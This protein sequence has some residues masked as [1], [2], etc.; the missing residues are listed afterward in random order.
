MSAGPLQ[1]TSASQAAHLKEEEAIGVLCRVNSVAPPLLPPE[2]PCA[3][4][5]FMHPGTSVSD[6]LPVPLATQQQDMMQEC[7]QAAA[8]SEAASSSIAKICTLRETS[9]S[10]L[11]CEDAHNNELH[12]VL[13][14]HGVKA[15]RLDCSYEQDTQLCGI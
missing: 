13:R 5:P 3:W 10:E 7:W 14:A 1:C 11:T 2:K 6:S 12:E 15:P 4:Q 9:N 8:A